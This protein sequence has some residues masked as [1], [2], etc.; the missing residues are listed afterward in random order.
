[1]AHFNLAIAVALAPAAFVAVTLTGPIAWDGF[2]SFWVRNGAI[3]LW[4]A[5]MTIVLG[6]NLYRERRAGAIPEAGFAG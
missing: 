3:A 2:L 4:L 1:V 6:R 5:V